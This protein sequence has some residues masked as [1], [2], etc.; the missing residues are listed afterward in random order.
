MI[1]DNLIFRFFNKIKINVS[2]ETRGNKND[3]TNILSIINQLTFSDFSLKL[4]IL[5]I[6]SVST[7]HPCYLSCDMLCLTLVPPP[8]S[9]SHRL[10][11]CDYFQSFRSQVPGRSNA[12]TQGRVS[13]FFY[14]EN[15]LI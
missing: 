8:L 11:G 15:I 3:N 13:L 12:D 1:L 5:K 6:F 2:F 7:F 9:A 14:I 10:G 4:S